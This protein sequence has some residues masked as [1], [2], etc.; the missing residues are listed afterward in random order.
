MFK[1]PH[2]LRYPPSRLLN[3]AKE[4]KRYQVPMATDMDMI[5]LWVLAQ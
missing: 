1:Q 3:L 4:V 5:V 2:G